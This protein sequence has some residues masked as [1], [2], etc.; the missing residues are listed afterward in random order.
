MDE[1]TM[2]APWRAEL[3]DLTALRRERFAV[4]ASVFDREMPEEAVRHMVATAQ[5][6]QE[7]VDEPDDSAEGRL[8]A[9]LATLA[10]DDMAEFATLT[11]T[12]YARLF[13]GPR[14]VVAPL[15]E[16]AYRSGTPRMFTAETLAVRAFYERH[17]YILK[18]KNREPEDAI[19]TEL[20]FMRN[21]C[22]GLLGA[23]VD[24]SAAFDRPAVEGFLRALGSFSEQHL[25][26][27]AA[28]FTERVREGDRSGFYAAWAAYLDEVLAED[29][30]L[31]R[32]SERLLG[33]ADEA[34]G[35]CRDL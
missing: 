9:A 7:A 8:G 30:A 14:E 28:H 35:R 27:W 3:A 26:R 23:L 25:D 22:D 13:L 1:S 16:S 10:R 31:Q 32:E 19:G 2:G 17:G 29:A 20:E 33:V 12:E 24:D 34:R 11:R 5:E 21:L 4:A 18:A 6:A 15:H